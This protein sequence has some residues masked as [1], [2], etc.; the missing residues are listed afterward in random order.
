ME[1]TGASGQLDQVLTLGL[2]TRAHIHI[3]HSLVVLS[4][5]TADLA[6]RCSLLEV[7]GGHLGAE[8]PAVE[9]EQ[10]AVAE[11][12]LRVRGEQARVGARVRPL[13]QHAPQ[14][15]LS[16]VF[17]SVLDPEI[18]SAVFSSLVP[19]SVLHA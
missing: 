13:P 2:N 11:H 19:Q 16:L 18:G 5:M 6:R 1:V 15:G 9:A 14:P 10:R 4:L 7:T 17:I 12:A 3:A 8:Q